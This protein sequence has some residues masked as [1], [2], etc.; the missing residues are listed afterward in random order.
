MHFS[1]CYYN[2]RT[3][4]TK[5]DDNILFWIFLLNSKKPFYLMLVLFSILL[6]GMGLGRVSFMGSNY[7]TL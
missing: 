3:M 6:L 7:R 5:V 2:V 4:L 1:E